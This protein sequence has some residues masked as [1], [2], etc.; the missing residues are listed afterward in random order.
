MSSTAVTP[1]NRPSE[2]SEPKREMGRTSEKEKTSRNLYRK[3]P[4]TPVLSPVLRYCDVDGFVKPY[5]AHHCRACGT[6][7]SALW[8]LIRDVAAQ[9]FLFKCVLKYDHHCPCTSSFGF[10][11]LSLTFTI[12][13]GIGGCVGAR[14]YKFFINFCFATSIFTAFLFATVLPFVVKALKSSNGLVGF[15]PRLII[16]LVLAGIFFLF[17]TLL[18]VNHVNIIT[19]GQ[20]TVESMNIRGMK[21]RDD[22]TLSRGYGWWEVRWAIL[23]MF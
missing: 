23:F 5:R 8:F 14:N 17:T 10:I 11:Y 15:D 4:S 6:V 13:T 3:V 21:D 18:C 22:Y 19:H 2:Q 20:T 7:S 16:L 9:G 1:S 12:F